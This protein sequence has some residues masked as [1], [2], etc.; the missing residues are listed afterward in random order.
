MPDVVGWLYCLCKGAG[1][2]AFFVYEYL[3]FQDGAVT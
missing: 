3:I 1:T 2:E